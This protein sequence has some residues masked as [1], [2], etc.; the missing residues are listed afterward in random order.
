M[1]I[2][3]LLERSIRWG[4]IK[5][6]L[7]YSRWLAAVWCS[8]TGSRSRRDDGMD[9]LDKLDLSGKSISSNNFRSGENSGSDLDY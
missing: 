7:S 1:A 8:K 2:A 5:T 9:N 3:F 6:F 4:Y